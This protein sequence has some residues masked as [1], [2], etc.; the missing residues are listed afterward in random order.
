MARRAGTTTAP[1]TRG[2]PRPCWCAPTP[3]PRCWPEAFAAAG[4][5]PGPGRGVAAGP[6]RGQGRRS[7]TCAAPTRSPTSWPTCERTLPASLPAPRAPGRRPGSGDGRAR[8]VRRAPDVAGHQARHRPGHGVLPDRA[9]TVGPAPHRG[10][11]GQPRRAG[12][13]GPR[14]PGPRPQAGAVDFGAWLRS[15][16]DDD[17]AERRR[18]GDRHL[19][20][21]Q[22]PGVADRARRRP[23]EG[24]RPDPPRRGR[25]PRPSRRNAGCS[26]WPSPGPGTS[27]TAPGPRRRAF[28]SRVAAPQPS[29]WLEDI[30][31]TSV[32]AHS[33]PAAR[34]R[35]TPRSAGPARA[36][37]ARPSL[38]GDDQELFE[39]LRAG[40]R[41][42]PRPPRSRPTSCSTT[43][44]CA[45]SSPSGP[46]DQ[47]RPAA[48]PS[49]HRRRSR[50]SGSAPT[51][52]IVSEARAADGRARHCGAGPTAEPAGA[53]IPFGSG[54][55]SA[56]KAPGRKARNSASASAHSR[57]PTCSVALAQILRPS[58][59]DQPAVAA[60]APRPAGWDCGSRRRGARSCP[61]CPTATASPPAARRRSP[62]RT[63]RARNPA[64]PRMPGR[65]SPWP[66]AREGSAGS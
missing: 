33:Q 29:P 55:S 45:R 22:G 12:P 31:A 24:L 47:H 36:G 64:G 35:P 41:T 62:P 4:P 6:A 58:V 18:G 49:G 2:E 54:A 17:R 65:R 59:A 28:G 19:P 52:S 21:R 9:P 37:T 61:G 32:W 30:R 63:P 51:C 48:G 66:A 3:R 57:S 15:T 23:G 42:R 20:R 39:A 53:G 16:L 26:T 43:P 60:A 13:P 44:P 1:A 5:P 25:T 8:T 11:A 46:T 40:A 56:S 27:C 38:T 34:R 7:R 50:Q 10:T 14:V